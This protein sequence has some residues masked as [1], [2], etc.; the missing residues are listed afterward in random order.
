MSIAKCVPPEKMREYLSGWLDEPE[1]DSIESHLRRCSQCELRISSLESEPDSLAVQVRDGLETAHAQDSDTPDAA[2]AYALRQAKRLPV[3]ESP[4][5]PE[6]VEPNIDSHIGPYEIE[7]SLGQGGMGCVYLGKHSQLHKRVAIKVLPSRPFRN[8]HYAARFKREIR[9]AGQLNHPAIVQATDAGQHDGTH[10]LVMEFVDG[11]DV[12]RIARLVGML[13][14][15]DACSIAKTVAL[16]LSHAHAMGVVHRDIKPSNLMISQSGDVKILD[17]GLAH[18]SLWDEASAELTTVGQLM[19]TLDYMAPEQAER[20]EAVDYRADLYSLG[21]TLFRLLC[22]RAPLVASPGL[23][24]LAKLRV[25]ATQKSPKLDTLRPDAP[26]KLVGLVERLLARDPNDRPASAAHVAEELSE[27]VEKADLQSLVSKAMLADNVA[28]NADPATGETWRPSRERE[29][30]ADQVGGRGIRRIGW[31]VAAAMVPLALLGIFLTLEWGKGQL[32]IESDVANVEVKV[33]Q[34]GENYHKLKVVPGANA[35][36]LYAGKYEIAID[37]AGHELELDQSNIE[38]KSGSTVIARIRSQ[39]TGRP[40]NASSLTKSSEPVYNGKP[41]ADWL[42]QFDQESNLEQL[43]DS[44]Q[45]ISALV[46]PDKKQMVTERLWGAWPNKRDESARTGHHKVDSATFRILLNFPSPDEFIHRA[47]T[48]LRKDNTIWRQ[49]LVSQLTKYFSSV[50]NGPH[51]DI[52]PIVDTIESVLTR[53]EKD[54]PLAKD[55]AGFL[56]NGLF[57]KL[58]QQSDRDRIARVLSTTPAVGSSY[59]FSSSILTHVTHADNSLMNMIQQKAVE[60]IIDESTSDNVVV[61]AIIQLQKVTSKASKLPALEPITRR[62]ELAKAIGKR[63]RD[64]TVDLGALTRL[65]NT[66]EPRK[67]DFMDFLLDDQVG[68]IG[69]NSSPTFMN[70]VAELVNL[71]R[72]LELDDSIQT[73]LSSIRQLTL[74]LVVQLSHKLIPQ[75]RIDRRKSIH[76]SWP[77]PGRLSFSDDEP[78]NMTE[79]EWIAYLVLSSVAKTLTSA[80]LEQLKNEIASKRKQRIIA[81]EVKTLDTDQNGKLSYD[82]A[83]KGIPSPKEVDTDQDQIISES[84]LLSYRERPQPRGGSSGTRG[85]PSAKSQPTAVEPLYDGRPL[86]D[87]LDTFTRETSENKLEEALKAI[88]ALRNEANQLTIYEHLWKTTPKKRNYIFKREVIEKVRGSGGRGQETRTVTVSTPMDSVVFGV[89]RSCVPI[90]DF[91]ERMAVELKSTDLSWPH[92]I[93]AGDSLP[94]SQSV[95]DLQPLLNVIAD[96]PATSQNKDLIHFMANLIV[97]QLGELPSERD[98]SLMEIL[99]SAKSLDNDYWLSKSPGFGFDGTNRF[100]MPAFVNAVQKR[101]VDVF[102]NVESSLP[103]V[104]QAAKIL[105]QLHDE[106]LFNRANIEPLPRA[107]EMV[108]ALRSRLKSLCDMPEQLTQFTEVPLGSTP[109]RVSKN[110]GNLFSSSIV[111]HYH[112]EVGISFKR[113]TAQDLIYLATSLKVES[114]LQPEMERLMSSTID[115]T[116]AFAQM[117]SP[118]PFTQSLIAISLS[119]HPPQIMSNTGHVDNA[120]SV[121]EK[122]WISYFIFCGAFDASS[123]EVQKKWQDEFYSKRGLSVAASLIAQWDLNKNEKLEMSEISSK[124]QNASSYDIDRDGALDRDELLKAYRLFV[125]RNVPRESP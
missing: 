3:A 20:A 100:A 45:A 63:L 90:K 82:E 80:E 43:T 34:G 21:A 125:H 50:A 105:E 104:L 84:E 61:Q 46:T 58:L 89:L 64:R 96:K 67:L 41:L 36:R 78:R 4:E 111:F 74:G 55:M 93:V 23:S 54:S 49:R 112:N 57:S 10:Y 79:Q 118:N 6:R 120:R 29:Q 37:G 42:N 13:N 62:N 2:V 9:T 11:L 88:A 44:I 117:L 16:G 69:I 110:S 72:Q 66:E 60:A 12:S 85:A 77:L 123:V 17:F 95:T 107:D 53:V 24:P 35:T 14:V 47:A 33:L 15:P 19:G 38:I 39:V 56:A 76:V 92:R 52:A 7:R 122:E 83:S 81:E 65:E 70:V 51:T 116:L 114:Q 26:P 94:A 27:F 32:I 8:D 113:V 98:R 101:A 5:P 75:I 73:E 99:L 30:K 87:W 103:H 97:K 22:G 28:D 71:A 124:I 31:L 86:A 102:L 40:S 25:L 106:L 59:W 115:Q 109:F 18:V 68:G 108:V 119:I 1:S 48:E 121:S 91:V